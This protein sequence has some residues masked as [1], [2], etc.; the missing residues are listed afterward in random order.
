MRKKRLQKRKRESTMHEILVIVPK[1]MTGGRKVLNV[2]W[3]I[4]ACLM[5]LC[6]T[7]ITPIIFF[8][9]AVGFAVLW[10]FQTFRMETEWEYTYY[11]GDLRFARIRAK[12]KRKNLATIQ[13]DDVIAIAPRGDRSI[14]KYETDRTVTYKD[15]TS[16]EKDAKVYAVIC[17]GD[18]NIVRYEIEPDEELLDAIMVK[19]SRI[20]TK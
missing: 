11:D 3:F 8:V 9:P 17:K 15:L 1:K 13:M 2:V 4:L 10:Y 6:A 7:F 19:Y 18:K 16:G 12:S 5:F 14:Y 20:V